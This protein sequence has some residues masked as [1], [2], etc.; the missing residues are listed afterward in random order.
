MKR[1]R[2][3]KID[4]GAGKKKRVSRTARQLYMTKVKV[5]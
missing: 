1:G 4:F 3:L 2:A 5:L